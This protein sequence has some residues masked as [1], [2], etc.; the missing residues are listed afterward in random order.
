MK[1]IT[2]ELT[3]PIFLIDIEADKTNQHQRSGAGKPSL[4]KLVY[5]YG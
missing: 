5:H 4:K 3:M 1:A 2:G